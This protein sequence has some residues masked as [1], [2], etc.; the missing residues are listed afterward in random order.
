MTIRVLGAADR[1][2][3]TRLLLADPVFNVFVSSRVAAGVLD[4]HT[5]GEVWGFPGSAPRSLLHVGA[6]LVPVNAD[7]EALRAFAGRL[8][9]YRPCC[10]ILGPTGQVQTLW[11]LLSEEWGGTYADAR[12]VRERQP[13]MAT[14]LPAPI[15]PD[16][17]VRRITMADFDSY[18]AAAVAMYTEELDDDPLASNPVGYRRYMASLVDLGRAFGI[19]EDGEV[20]FK[21]D[22]GAC[23]GGVSQVQGVWV[24][25][26]LRG[27]G[28]A[29][30]AMAAVTD[31]IVRSGNTASLYVNDFNAPAIATY[32]RCGYTERGVFTTV[33]Y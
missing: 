30:P 26:R 25:P 23:G 3:V 2:A 13:V 31:H 5:S 21:A 12:A 16:P 8:G 32:R 17:R 7:A 20:I 19:V 6:N 18:F 15:A 22:L 24:A 28:I 33:L 4:R 1:H 14:D 29:A 10:A 11:R 9:P 27:R